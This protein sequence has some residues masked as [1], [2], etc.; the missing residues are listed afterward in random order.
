M[1]CDRFGILISK[2][3]D[4]FTLLEFNGMIMIIRIEL[5]LILDTDCSTLYLISPDSFPRYRSNSHLGY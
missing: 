4:T 2:N 1:N 5:I 3:K